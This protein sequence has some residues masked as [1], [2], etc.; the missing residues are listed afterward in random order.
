MLEN[1]KEMTQTLKHL[2]QVREGPQLRSA[3]R[4]VA[5]TLIELLVVIAIIAML[6]AMLLPALSRA[7][8]QSKRVYCLNNQRQIGFAFKMYTDDANEKYP[9][10]DGW[11]SVGGQCPTNAFVGG[12]AYSYGGNIAQTNRPLNR[13]AVNVNVFHCP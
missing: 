10:H 9:V 7:K 6:A 8:A 12:D 4:V 2:R 3:E 1:P 11:A 13:Y 5:F